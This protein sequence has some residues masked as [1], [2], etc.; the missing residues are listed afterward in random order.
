LRSGNHARVVQV[1]S[2][3]A[4]VNRAKTPITTGLSYID[5][6]CFEKIAEGVACSALAVMSDRSFRRRRRQRCRY[7]VRQKRRSIAA[8][9]IDLRSPLNAPPP[10]G[11]GASGG[12]SRLD[13]GGKRRS[14]RGVVHHIRSMGGSTRYVMTSFLLIPRR[15][16]CR[17]LRRLAQINAKLRTRRAPL[18]RGRVRAHPDN[19]ILIQIAASPFATTRGC[20]NI[21]TPTCLR[22]P[23]LTTSSG[24]GM[25]LFRIV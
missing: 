4:F 7:F 15:Y 24:A 16:S 14:L 17:D 22:F 11:R 18:L 6:C 1:L 25:N 10:V 9:A 20:R 8:L 2:C 19:S 23:S 12:A 13:L 5:S 21:F 3:Q